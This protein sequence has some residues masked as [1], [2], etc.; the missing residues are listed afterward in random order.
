MTTT[1]RRGLSLVEVMVAIAIMAIVVT[2]TYQTLATATEVTNTNSVK[3]GLEDDARKVIERISREHRAASIVSLDG[4]AA[5]PGSQKPEPATYPAG[6]NDLTYSL[7]AAAD[8]VTATASNYPA[9]RIRWVADPQ[10]P[11]DDIDNDHDGLTD[12]GTV[13]LTS[14]RLNNRDDDGDGAIDEADDGDP[15]V[16]ETI[17]TNVARFLEGEM[18]NGADDN[19]NGLVDESGLCFSFDSTTSLMT[20]RV[21]IEGTAAG[22]VVIR[23]TIQTSVKLMNP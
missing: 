10:D 22:G 17:A 7:L 19:G 15:V 4:D 11:T 23:A 21:T 20:I 5:T 6:T 8:P 18:G 12:E 13:E 16:I 2:V 14:I 1:A 3:A 9:S